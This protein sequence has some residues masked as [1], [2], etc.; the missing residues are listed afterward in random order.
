MPLCAVLVLTPL[1]TAFL[2]LHFGL[3][4]LIA[5]L[6]CPFTLILPDDNLFIRAC[7][8]LRNRLLVSF[9]HFIFAVLKSPNS[10]GSSSASSISDCRRSAHSKGAKH[11]AESKRDQHDQ[12]IEPVVAPPAVLQ[13]PRTLNRRLLTVLEGPLGRTLMAFPSA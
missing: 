4:D 1:R 9:D 2:L 6:F 7:A 12:S 10:R 11:A 3:P 5:H 8:L 13:S